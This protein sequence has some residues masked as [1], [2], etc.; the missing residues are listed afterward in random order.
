MYL[1]LDN[2]RLIQGD[3]IHHVSSI[4]PVRNLMLKAHTENAEK[5]LLKAPTKS[6]PALA[7]YI[8]FAQATSLATISL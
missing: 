6:S 5:L 7:L 8:I 4:K 1:P 3:F 2:N